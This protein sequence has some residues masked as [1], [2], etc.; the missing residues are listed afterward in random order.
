MQRAI[1]QLEER[2][3]ITHRVRTET[4]EEAANKELS[5][6]KQI[7]M[8]M[9]VNAETDKAMRHD[10]HNSLFTEKGVPFAIDTKKQKLYVG[11]NFATLAKRKPIDPGHRILGIAHKRNDGPMK[12]KGLEADWVAGKPA[13]A[14]PKAQELITDKISRWIFAF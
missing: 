6:L 12:L 7:F 9:K 14:N 5:R 13:L 8:L 10:L 1:R 3:K 2:R 11:E 4:A